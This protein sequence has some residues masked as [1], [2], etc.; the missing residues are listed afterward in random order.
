MSTRDQAGRFL[1]G[2]PSPNPL[3]RAAASAHSYSV[4]KAAQPAGYDGV[5]SYGGYIHTGESSSKLTGS[6]KWIEYANAFNYPPVAIAALLR[7][8]LLSGAKWSLAENESGSKDAIAGMEIVEQGLLKA[9]MSEPWA[10]VVAKASMSWF[11]GSS[12]HATAMGRRKDGM[13]V[14]TDIAHRPMHTIQ[15]WLGSPFDAVEQRITDGRI[16]TIPLEECLYI[17]ERMLSDDPFGVGVLRL[18]IER[19]RRAGEYE[20]LEGHEMFNSMG[21]TPIARVPGQ[22]INAEIASLPPADKLAR[23]RELTSNI[24]AIVD[25]RIKNPSKRQYAVLDSATYQGSDPNTIS[26]IKKWDIEIIKGDL[27]GLADIRKTISDHYIDVARILGVEFVYVG[28]GDSAGTYGMHESKVGVF[29]ASLQTGLDRIAERAT[30]QLCRRL[31]AANGLD[32]DIA[33]PRL[34][35]E[36]ITIASVMDVVSVLESLT[37]AGLN[38]SD[39]ARNIVRERVGLPP[40]PEET[41]ADLMLPRKPVAVVPRGEEPAA[42]VAPAPAEDVT[43]PT[44]TP[45]ETP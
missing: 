9:R 17:V 4:T 6:Q 18:V 44:D 12:L 5:I 30:Q 2:A 8:A 27:Q 1:K 42:D 13:V 24:T 14:Y 41:V 3:G 45:K 16:A 10:E 21:G 15:R 33:C 31:V 38:P 34:V 19:L 32:P 22:D 37:R 11:Y 26:G 35:P 20:G 7:Y 23:R 25:E 28:G 39:P 29:A 36:K 40:E 43:P